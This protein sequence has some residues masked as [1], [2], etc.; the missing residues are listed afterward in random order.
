MTGRFY[1]LKGFTLVELLIVLMIISLLVAVVGPTLYQKINPAK[2]SAARA[3]MDNLSTA[4][5]SFLLDIGR[6]PTKREGL[7]VL[8]YK[9]GNLNKWNGPYVKKELPN[10]PWG[11]PYQ[12]RTPGTHG[13]F[14]IVSLGADGTEGGEKENQDLFSWENE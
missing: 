4:M 12:Y 9:P 6:Y 3:Q 10:D 7:D 8:F 5:D 1:R 14:E 2:A 13:Q 11:S